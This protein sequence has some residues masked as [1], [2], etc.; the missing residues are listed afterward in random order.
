[1]GYVEWMGGGGLHGA[2]GVGGWVCR[3]GYWEGL[4]M[5]LGKFLNEC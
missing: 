3:V 2:K 1:M 5:A 4:P